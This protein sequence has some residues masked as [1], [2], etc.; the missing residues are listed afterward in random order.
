VL[1]G[2]AGIVHYVIGRY[3][4]YA[5][6]E[7]IGAARTGPVHTLGLPYSVLIAYLFLDE[8]ITAG[9][10][11]GMVL[12][13]IG[14]LIMVERRR[15][16]PVSAVAPLTPGAP[17]DPVAAIGD[18]APAHD[19]KP[20]GFQLRQAEGYLFAIIAAVAYGSSPVLIRSA[21]EGESGISLFGGLVSYVA[22]G[23]LLIASLALPSRRHLVHALEPASLRVFFAPGFFVFMAQVFRFLSLSLASV[24][25]VATLLR[26]TTIFTLVL[27]YVMNRDLEKITWRVLAGV[28]LSLAGAI[29]LVVTST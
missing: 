19:E 15:H 5:A 18:S 3:F 16:A 27:S 26:F 28:L 12:I 6:I 11:A 9:M 13:M 23:G 1:L 4:N 10:V 2:G 29:L 8:G 14:P 24:A 21:L 17:A 20:E 7:A 25:V 22:A